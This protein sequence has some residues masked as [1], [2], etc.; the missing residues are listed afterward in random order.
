MGNKTIL[1]S[2]RKALPE[3][4]DRRINT[5]LMTSQVALV[6]KNPPA[7]AGDIKDV[8]LIPGKIP[9][10]EGITTQSSILAWRI[11]WTEET[12]RLQSIDSQS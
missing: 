5:K 9:L 10:E 1:N 2:Y 12:D 3:N 8:V 4:W 6:V 7:N 11:S